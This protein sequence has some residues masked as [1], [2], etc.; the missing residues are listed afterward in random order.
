MH[1][2]EDNN[3][4]LLQ[5]ISDILDLSK[6]EAGTLE[7]VYSNV[8]INEL[9]YNLEDSAKMRNKNQKVQI[10]YNKK[11]QE[12]YID[13]DKNRLTQV[14]S[15][16]L[17]NAMKFTE[18]GSIEFG[19]DL[20]DDNFLHFYVTDTGSGIPKEQLACVFERF[21]KLN[22]FV[23]GTGLG[24]SICQTIIE[25]MGGQ[26]G[27]TSKEGEGTTFWFTLPYSST[28]KNIQ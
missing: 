23:Q 10:I 13:T 16:L 19:Y 8:D 27:V 25:T 17:N 15:N 14:V 2:I 5:L 21:I 26:I 28:A 24:L 18:K 6:I 11:I 12:C 7:F 1:I 9:F 4:L 20:Q 22:D 3:N